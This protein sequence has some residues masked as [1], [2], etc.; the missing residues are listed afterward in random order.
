MSNYHCYQIPPEYQ[1]SPIIWDSDIIGEFYGV[2]IFGN[3]DFREHYPESV[4]S[5]RNFIMRELW[6]NADEI[7]DYL[8]YYG[9]KPEHKKRFS[10][11]DIAK[12][13][14]IKNAE[15]RGDIPE[16]DAITEIMEIVTGEA[17]EMYTIRGCVQRD[18]NILFCPKS[19]PRETINTIEC[20]Y[21]NTGAE[22]K[23]EEL[24]GD[25]IYTHDWDEDGIKKEIAD[26]ISMETDEENISICLHWFKGWRKT[27]TYGERW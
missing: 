13:Y 4:E 27:A 18:W 2:A 1:E 23:I 16:N 22:W 7:T 14:R 21:F 19:T 11:L 9:I 26:Y 20:E 17:W 8:E 12:I 10:A 3:P 5:V 15:A 24:G 6:I 25:R